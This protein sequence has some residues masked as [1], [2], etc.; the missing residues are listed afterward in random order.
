[1]KVSL[2]IVAL[3]VLVTACA[4]KNQMKRQDISEIKKE[5]YE[6]LKTLPE[7]EATKQFWEGRKY[8]F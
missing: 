4:A 1:M 6:W 5:Y 3:A 7:P 8:G 2:L